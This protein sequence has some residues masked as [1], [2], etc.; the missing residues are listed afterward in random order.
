MRLRRFEIKNF[1]CIEHLAVDWD[2][3][4]VLIGEN[5]SGKSSVLLALSW[6]LS[7]SAI[8]DS[9]L[10]RKHQTGQNDAI[11]LTGYF[12]QL[13]GRER[14]Q[15]AVKGR[16]HN[17]EWILKK[18]FW[19][20]EVS[21]EDQEKGGW[22]EQLYSY[23][24]R[25]SF[26]NWPEPDNSWN[27]FPAD[28]QPLIQQIPDR[29]NRPNI[30]A[31]E[32]LRGIIRQ[33]RPDL[34]VQG[35][36]E[37]IPNPGGGGNW[38]SNANSIMPRV[39]FVRAVHEATDETNAKDA[40]TYGKLINL[41]VERSLS[42]R[43]EMQQL[44]SAIEA[45]LQLFRPD[46]AHPERQADEIRLLQE[47]INRGLSD[48]IGGQALI[49]T[50][51]PELG[52]LV[53]PNTTLVIRDPLAGIETQVTHQG[54]GLQRTLVMTLLQLLTEAQ[55]QAEEE[56]V[57]APVE[58]RPSILMVE[59]P[60]LYMH[61]QVERRMRDVL[62]KLATQPNTQVVCCTHSP[63]FL[64][65]ANKYQA[66]VRLVKQ[67]DGKVVGHQ[68]IQDLFPGQGDAVEK[69]R[70][71]AV[72]RFN[73]TVNELFFAGQVVLLEEFSAIVAFERAGEMTGLFTRHPHVRRGVC[74]VDCAGKDSI[75]G[76]QRVLNKFNIAYRVIHD[77][78][79]GNPAAV[80]TNQK[81]AVE[82][83][84]NPAA[85]VFALQPVDLESMLGYQVPSKQKPLRA[86]RRIEEL[87]QQNAIPRAFV[88]AM[89]MVYFGSPN[90]PAPN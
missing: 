44:R 83:T 63:V 6:F 76:F 18:R 56:G 38:K 65:I 37:W 14:E 19:L 25:E 64:D 80:A 55:E 30:A 54:H 86:Y 66:I 27:G 59:E 3:L 22:K 52:S 50:E 53:M 90:E 67:G 31:R 88:E 74:L 71:Q 29:P 85:I 16:I 43:Q 4:L 79:T 26:A 28:Y 2:D 49:K 82:A 36:P 60:E 89:N 57:A 5:N 84:G 35:V 12:D 21:P 68:V 75:P 8:K 58:S 70:L 87:K 1:K 46:E 41:I 32:V 13:S 40:S 7:G 24:T 10:F 39:V 72:A 20:E 9:S 78:D 69:Q 77:A 23:S 17:D 47:R 45:V 81:I 42:K 73:P 61:P 34:V 51:P 62:Y 11:E 15:V 33:Q 48:V